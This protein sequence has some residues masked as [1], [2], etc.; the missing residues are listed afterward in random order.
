M[1]GKHLNDISKV[2]LDTIAN[3]KK[4][5]TDADIKRWQDLGGPTPG[6]YRADDNSAKLKEGRRLR[7]S[8]WRQDLKEVIDKPETEDQA[9]K[10]VTE[11]KVKNKVVI[12]P[13]FKEA[14]EEI[15]GELLEVNEVDSVEKT[16]DDTQ[17]RQEAHKKQLESK[18]KKVAAMKKLVLRKK[19]Q[20]V[21]AGGGEDITAGY[22]P[23]GEVIEG[24]AKPKI[25]EK[26]VAK[27]RVKKG[28]KV[29]GKHVKEASAVL[30]ANKKLNKESKTKKDK[31]ELAKLTHIYK[32]M[33]KG[34]YNSYEPEGEV[35]VEKD[36]SAAERRALPNKD[37]VFPGKG[38]GPEGKQR[39]AYP[40]NDKKHARAALAMAAAHASPEK[41][42]KVKAAVKK[43]YPEIEVSEAAGTV[44]KA[45]GKWAV[46]Q[47]IK[48]GGK[49][50]GKFVKRAGKEAV[51]AAGEVAVETGKGVV[52]A[53]KKR[54][55]KAGEDFAT[56]VGKKKE[57]DEGVLQMV[58]SIGRK[59]EERKPKK[60]MDAG[61]IAKRKLARAYHAKYVSGSEDNV[62]DDIRDHYEVN[63]RTL[64]SYIP[65]DRQGEAHAANAAYMKAQLKKREDEST[66]NRGDL[67]KRDAGKMAKERLRN[68]KIMSMGE[69]KKVNEADDKAYNYVVG[70]LKKKYGDGVLTKGD[71]MPEPSAAQKKKNAEIRA[72]RAKEDHRDPTEKASDGRYSDRY[73]N[74]GSD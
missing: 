55:R 34:I 38:E 66:K 51:K 57:V 50:G 58:K 3:V 62:P 4:A 47:G 63:E 74:R 68:K 71:K 1:S 21:G 52:D 35:V 14:I 41:E 29:Q 32:G 27:V 28:A 26:L 60:A 48:V 45:A 18:Q 9:E 16:Q 73:S 61:A 15:G 46:R 20:A 64:S 24:Y 5:E 43:K 33:K 72:K 13:S 70:M 49:A 19:M 56:N 6:N 23:E 2:Y 17:K 39:G 44:V 25:P 22:E 36:L 37:F 69:A 65:S 30:D 11:K 7:K 12:N 40:I 54:G 10:E 53:A 59:K 31:A 8:D 42:A 67:S